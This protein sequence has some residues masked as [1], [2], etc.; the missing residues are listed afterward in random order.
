MTKRA[1][2][3]II[4]ITAILLLITVGVIN[5]R[6]VD[7]YI[8]LPGKFVIWN[9]DYGAIIYN[10]GYNMMC[11]GTMRHIGP[12][13]GGY[14]V[15]TNVIV[16]QITP[17]PRDDEYSTMINQTGNERRP[18]YFIIDLHDK[19]VY[20]GMRKQDWLVQLKTYGI[21]EEPKLSKPSGLD[22]FLGRNRPRAES[23]PNTR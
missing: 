6:I 15:Y 18:G 23:Q 13:V 14:H 12:N 9:S 19:R 5:R 2:I 8:Y 3:S 20:G 10:K 7:Y 4:W 1:R 22:E 21:T 11:E 17:H 16:G